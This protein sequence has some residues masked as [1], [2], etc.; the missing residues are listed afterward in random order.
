MTWKFRLHDGIL[1]LMKTGCRSP[2][3]YFLDHLERLLNT[4]LTITSQYLEKG[5][6]AVLSCG[7]F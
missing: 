2:A 3:P 7:D 4:S 1:V 5:T 6:E